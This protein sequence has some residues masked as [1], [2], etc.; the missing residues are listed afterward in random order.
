MTTTLVFSAIVS[1]SD[2]AVWSMDAEDMMRDGI[3]LDGEE[4]LGIGKD[5]VM[6]YEVHGTYEAHG[7]EEY[8]YEGG[9]PDEHLIGYEGL[10]EAE[11]EIC[12]ILERELGQVHW[13]EA[14]VLRW[15]FA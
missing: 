11:D 9:E 15:A 13:V 8:G 12:G 2:M 5:G 7:I 10:D 1:I 3:E 6:R 4:E 14:E